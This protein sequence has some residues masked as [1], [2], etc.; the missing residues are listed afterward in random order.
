MG[1]SSDVALA[2][3]LHVTPYCLKLEAVGVAAYEHKW[4]SIIVSTIQY[5]SGETFAK[6]V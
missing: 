5:L 6:I 1:L 3:L 4:P 2:W